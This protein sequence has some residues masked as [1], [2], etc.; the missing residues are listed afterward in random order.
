M[1]DARMNGAWFF[2]AIGAY[3][4]A[5]HPAGTVGAVS[6]AT[7]TEPNSGGMRR[8]MACLRG[9]ADARRTAG[10][11]EHEVIVWVACGR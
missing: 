11:P 5:E 2:T 6:T 7:A 9:P 1:T 8:L 10:P 4:D 3:L